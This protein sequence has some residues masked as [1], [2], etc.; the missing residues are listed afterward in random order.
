MRKIIKLNESDLFKI[1]NRVISEQ[2][3]REPNTDPTSVF[4]YRARKQLTTIE[5][6]Q[7][8]LN[9]LYGGV[10]RTLVVDGVYGKKTRAAVRKFQLDNPPLVPDG[11]VGL[12]T[13]RALGVDPLTDEQQGKLKRGYT[14]RDKQPI[15][16]PK[17]TPSSSKQKKTKTFKLWPKLKKE[18]SD[19]ITEKNFK[20]KKLP[21][22][23]HKGCANFVNNI[24]SEHVSSSA[25]MSYH[26][27]VGNRIWSAF[28]NVNPN[29][30]KDILKKI[31]L[32]GG[33]ED[34]KDTDENQKI[35]ALVK[36]LNGFTGTLELGDR[37]GIFYEPSRH[38]EMALTQGV[39]V[40]THVKGKPTFNTHTGIVGA[41]VDGEPIIFH[42]I[43]GKE[44]A[45][46]A[47]KLKIVW[48]KRGGV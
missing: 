27:G 22:I 24:S 21:D 14:I 5:K 23:Q 13:A 38:Y 28:D 15:K 10:I 41:M 16:L 25:W 43:N 3:L 37:V 4:G 44:I 12:A 46:P 20:D 6:I 9:D 11:I 29:S 26:Y 40:G 1:I 33:V 8:R 31:E 45:D 48:V 36:S 2:Y 19:K 32:K 17:V 42:A 30:Y 35:R 47:S 7:D 18:Y 34:D 39:E